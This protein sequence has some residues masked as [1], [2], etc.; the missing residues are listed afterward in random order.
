M[1]KNHFTTTVLR[2]I[3][4]SHILILVVFV[5][6]WLCAVHQFYGFVKNQDKITYR[7]FLDIVSS[8]IDKEILIAE[9]AAVMTAFSSSM[10]RLLS[11]SSYSNRDITQIMNLKEQLSDSMQNQTA[12]VNAMVYFPNLDYIVGYNTT[13]TTP[14]YYITYIESLGITY[15]DWID[16]LQSK[17]TSGYYLMQTDATP[18]LYYVYFV[19]VQN[20]S[21][22]ALILFQIADSVIDLAK[23][24]TPESEALNLE[25]ISYNQE[26]IVPYA[27]DGENVQIIEKKSLDTGWIYR[28]YIK[29][30]SFKTYLN[31][32]NPLLLGG[33]I[34]S[35]LICAMALYFTLRTQ[36]QPIRSIV[37]ELER[38]APISHQKKDEYSYIAASLEKMV[39]DQ[40]EAQAEIE[41]QGEQLKQVY[42]RYLFSGK[43]KSGSVG[44][45]PLSLFGLQFVR[46]GFYLASFRILPQTASTA[47]SPL[48][49]QLHLVGPDGEIVGVR[50]ADDGSRSLYLLNYPMNHEEYVQQKL[51]S[52]LNRYLD[53]GC[54][55]CVLLSDFHCG[56]ETIYEAYKELAEMEKLYSSPE[57]SAGVYTYVAYK[58]E[59]RQAQIKQQIM[60]YIQTHYDDINLNVDE[61]CRAVNKSPSSVSKILKE[62]GDEGVL[63]HINYT[64]IQQA[65]RIF[66]EEKGNV[67]VKDVML[68]VGFE[69][70]NRFTRLFKKFEGMT[71]GEYCKS[72][73]D[74]FNKNYLQNPEKL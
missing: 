25:V 47:P 37:K 43:Y 74:D 64:R 63:Y 28:G 20:R 45:D 44:E 34:A 33:I 31:H 9:H 41:K 13:A 51:F 22:K 56:E 61:V 38:L 26:T 27:G 58:S 55:I 50:V 24:T 4:V 52:F 5:S 3:I 48:T 10:D 65:K 62:S 42:F 59:K 54:R 19:P 53:T 29:N 46:Q 67:A 49:E 40:K 1:K 12:I 6:L 32:V 18:I 15:D 60:E 69:N 35:T 71:P 39:Q 70:Q 16:F 66:A 7:N 68:R 23:T 36:Y 11:T 2:N 73:A 21:D 14:T 17:Q 57:R 30:D 72:C 8:G